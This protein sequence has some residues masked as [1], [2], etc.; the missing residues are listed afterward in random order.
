MDEIELVDPIERVCYLCLRLGSEFRNHT[1][2]ETVL[3]T[4]TQVVCVC[5]SIS[6]CVAKCMPGMHCLISNVGGASCPLC[7]LV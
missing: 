3:L 5:V 4:P 7:I 2:P 1:L 6:L